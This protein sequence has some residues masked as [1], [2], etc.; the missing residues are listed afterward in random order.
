M[1][2]QKMFRFYLKYTS[3]IGAILI[4][5]IVIFFLLRI[6]VISHVP[7]ISPGNIPVISNLKLPESRIIAVGSPTHGNSEPFKIV[8]AVLNDLY[9]KHNSVALILEELA[10]DAEIINS[11]HTYSSPEGVSVGMHSIYDNDEMSD[12][13]NWL[14]KFEQRLYGID[15][16]S[17]SGTTK[18]LSSALKDL[19]FAESKK[20]LDLVVTSRTAIVQNNTFLLAI[21]EFIRTQRD[22]K[23]ISDQAFTYLQ[24]LLDCIKMNYKYLLSDCSSQIRDEMMAKNVEWIM[25]YEST[26]FQNDYAVLF[27]SNGHAIKCNWSYDF[28]KDSYV[29][30]GAHLA[31]TYGENYFVILTDAQYN[32]FEALSNAA[33]RK[34]IFHVKNDHLSPFLT[35]SGNDTAILSKSLWSSNDSQDITLT[36]IG[37]TFST[38]RSLN[39]S[40][41]TVQVP[42]SDSCNILLGFKTMTPIS[43]HESR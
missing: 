10:G 6:I 36:I 3:K 27:A 28:I 26:Y 7:Q 32:N 11:L 2:N 29:P 25:N 5:S 16:Q 33:K 24:H 12:I 21:E 43:R 13:L 17:V 38:I 4:V 39:T 15:I 20:V 31:A 40:Y 34:D 41:Y 37:S 9:E 1:N 23:L 14:N 8:L 30:M 19:G 18:V 22:A 35:A 42:L